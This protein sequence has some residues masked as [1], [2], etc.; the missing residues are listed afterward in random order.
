MG[1]LER[2]PMEYVVPRYRA[3]VLDAVRESLAV[4]PKALLLGGTEHLARELVTVTHLLAPSLQHHQRLTAAFPDRVVVP[5]LGVRLPSETGAFDVAIV[6]D[7]F[8]GLCNALK[9]PIVRELRRVA[10]RIVFICSPDIMTQARASFG[11]AKT[12]PEMLRFVL[13]ALDVKVAV[14]AC[15]IGPHL[16]V[17][18]PS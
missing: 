6:T 2:L 8:G 3:E 13:T 9:V 10:T 14:R 7:F 17:E 5:A 16:L 18:V 4:A 11:W 1:R 15:R 12:D